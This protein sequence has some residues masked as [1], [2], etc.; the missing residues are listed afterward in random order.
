[1]YALNGPHHAIYEG[2]PFRSF[3]A[4]SCTKAGIHGLTLWLAGYWAERGATVNTIAPGAVF[5]GHSEEFQRRVGELI[6]MGRMAQP[7]EIA[8]AMLFLC[9]P[10]AGYMTGQLINVDGGFSGW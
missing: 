3:S 2:M 5:N 1:M 8:D 6:M 10:A 4:Y 9:S 7:D